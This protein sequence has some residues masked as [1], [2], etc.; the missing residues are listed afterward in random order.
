MSQQQIDRLLAARS[1]DA[2]RKIH[3]ENSYSLR[4]FIG[5]YSAVRRV[6]LKK[7]PRRSAGA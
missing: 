6:G 3:C 5:D 7:N 2:F 4:I 1:S